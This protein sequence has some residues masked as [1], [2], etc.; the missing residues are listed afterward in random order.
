[1]GYVQLFKHTI[2]IYTLAGLLIHCHLHKH[3]NEDIVDA[4][5]KLAMQHEL[6]EQIEFY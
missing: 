3:S 5:H 1:M 2:L 4:D 6:Q